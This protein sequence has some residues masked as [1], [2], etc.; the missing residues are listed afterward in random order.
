[1][2]NRETRPVWE[3]TQKPRADRG[4]PCDTYRKKGEN[5][6]IMS[7]ANV[8]FL[9]WV[10]YKMARH[11]QMTQLTSQSQFLSSK[12]AAQRAQNKAE[13]SDTHHKTSHA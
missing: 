1:M 10:W 8:Q 4:K 12:G 5:K 11:R 13:G 7:T 6:H 2:S 3:K 9:L